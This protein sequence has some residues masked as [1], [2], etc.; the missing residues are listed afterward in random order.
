[1]LNWFPLLA[2]RVNVVSNSLNG[3]VIIGSIVCCKPPNLCMDTIV[4]NSVNQNPPNI[5]ATVIAVNRCE[6][7][8]L[9]FKFPL[10]RL[11]NWGVYVVHCN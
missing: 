5:H 10:V 8:L 9:H 6:C 1:M 3:G 11:F 2:V 4:V 7:E